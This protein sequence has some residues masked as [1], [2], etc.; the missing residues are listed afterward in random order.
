MSETGME[1]SQSQGYA[2]E[3][4]SKESRRREA[5]GVSRPRLRRSNAILSE[6]NG[7]LD[8]VRFERDMMVKPLNIH[9]KSMK[10]QKPREN[11]QRGLV[12]SWWA[13]KLS[14]EVVTSSEHVKVNSFASSNMPSPREAL[15]SNPTTQDRETTP[16]PVPEI[17]I[18]E[19]EEDDTNRV[20][21]FSQE[22]RDAAER[23][24]NNAT[25]WRNNFLAS[26]P[27][28]SPV[29]RSSSPKKST[30]RHFEVLETQE[31]PRPIEQMRGLE[32]WP[33]IQVEE[34][35]S[36][37]ERS[38]NDSIWSSQ[39]AKNFADADA[40]CEWDFAPLERMPRRTPDRSR[41]RNLIGKPYL[42][43]I[44][45]ESH[46]ES[47][48]GIGLAIGHD[49]SGRGVPQSRLLSD[50]LREYEETDEEID[51]LDQD[52]ESFSSESSQSISPDSSE[53]DFA[54]EDVEDECP[55]GDDRYFDENP[56][57]TW[58]HDL[59]QRPR[60]P[61]PESQPVADYQMVP[62]VQQWMGEQHQTINPANSREEELSPADV[63]D[64]WAEAYKPISVLEK[65][66]R[67]AGR[68]VVV[69]PNLARRILADR[70]VYPK[71]RSSRSP[72]RR[73]IVVQAA[74][75]GAS[76]PNKSLNERFYKQVEDSH[77]DIDEGLGELCI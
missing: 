77:M 69:N 53:D 25:M 13:E 49:S 16:D 17:W 59:P 22:D 56:K 76:I 30:F 2:K 36:T 15:H 75:R 5:R 44:A 60:S 20:R 24:A 19:P 35:G 66:P 29:E 71:R 57:S 28:K 40:A 72:R 54:M 43:A 6:E 37:L 32:P 9:S 27:L 14:A 21:V 26:L 31:E 38:G 18:T 33:C 11:V 3:R 46:T 55:I 34:V 23:M 41:S 39:L 7:F 74:R 73:E 61:T 64:I 42:N 67:Y 12:N 50:E 47:G 10:K 48:L 58:Y 52:I 4:T 51:E 62:A 68:E 45:E 65:D 70:A 8:E 63:E 1:E